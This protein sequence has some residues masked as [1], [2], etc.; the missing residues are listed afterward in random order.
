PL[1]QHLALPAG[2]FGGETWG[3][4]ELVEGPEGP[5]W[6][7]EG[8]PQA[9]G[10]VKRLFLSA[11]GRG[12]G[13]AR[14]P[15]S[16]RTDQDLIWLLQRYPLRPKQPEQLLDAWRAACDYERRRA[17]FA[18]APR[19]AVAPVGFQGTLSP[20]KKEGLAWLKAHARGLLGDEMGLGKTVQ[21]LAFLAAV[22]PWPAVLVVPP[23]L[24]THWSAKLEAF[25]GIATETG[26]GDPSETRL[27]FTGKARAWRLQGRRKPGEGPAAADLYLLHYGLLDS[28]QP[29]L[30]QL[31]PRALAFDECQ[32]LRHHASLKYAAASK[33]AEAAEHVHGLSGTPIYNKGVEI[34]NVLNVLDFHCL[35]DRESF[36]REWTGT[37]GGEAISEPRV[38]GSYLKREGLL[39]RRLKADVLSELPAKRR[40][41]EKI[42]KDE[43]LFD[44]L[45]AEASAIAVEAVG[46]KDGFARSRIDGRA[47]T[48]I[49]KA[50]GL[51]KASFVAD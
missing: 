51:A 30:S 26:R 31:R 19:R 15:R 2:C 44:R 42:E 35:G 4:L 50:T 6:E 48:A 17:A 33:L 46:E 39:L 7:I 43:S 41:V 40:A 3:T 28:W 38:L 45:A 16:A 29:A 12:A 10:F 23:H 14:F 47:V 34:W 37:N 21:Y 5:V 36:T 25:L 22:E 18:A 1:P 9:V 49:R 13:Q 20:F 8:H 32:E 24:L 27:N 11:Q